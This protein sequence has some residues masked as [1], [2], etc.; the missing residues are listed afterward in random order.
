MLVG[1]DLGT[2][3][4]L[5]A[6]WKDG[7]AQLIPN[8]LRKYLTPSAVGL[9]DNGEILVGQPASERIITHPHRQRAQ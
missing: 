8:A 9:D 5:V 7:R 4:G 1:I 3:N 6:V 2:T